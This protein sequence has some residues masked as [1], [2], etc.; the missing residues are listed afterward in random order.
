LADGFKLVKTD[1]HKSHFQLYDI[2]KDNEERHK[3]AQKYPE[4]VSE[5]KAALVDQLDSDRPD[6]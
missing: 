4:R 6:L 1:R 3:L 2:R 5:M